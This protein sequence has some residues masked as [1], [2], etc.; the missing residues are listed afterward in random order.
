LGDPIP[1][2][3]TILQHQHQRKKH[4]R[5]LR[6]IKRLKNA[7]VDA[8]NTAKEKVNQLQKGLK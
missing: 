3:T 5:S 1:T 8:I 2:P 4:K 6:K 7:V